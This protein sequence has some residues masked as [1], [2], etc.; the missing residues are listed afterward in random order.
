MSFIR[1][2]KF[3]LGSKSG[4]WCPLLQKLYGAVPFCGRF[5]MQQLQIGIDVD[6]D[7]VQLLD[8]LEEAL[9]GCGVKLVNWTKPEGPWKRW[10]SMVPPGVVAY[11]SLIK[12]YCFQKDF[13]KVYNLLNE[14]Q[15]KGCPPD[16]ATYTIFMNAL[17]REKKI[18][19]RVHDALNVLKDMPRKGV[20]P[21]VKA[22]NTLF[23]AFC[24]Q[25]EEET[26]LKLLMKMEGYHCK[27]DVETYVPLLQKCCK[28]RMKLLF[29][30]LDYMLRNDVSPECTPYSL[31]VHGLC[32]SGKL[33]EACFFFED[34]VSRGMV[35]MDCSGMLMEEFRWNGM[36]MRWKELRS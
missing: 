18:D 26:A 6:V 25:N 22:C 20:I 13:E 29:F 2:E 16:V 15:E 24:A 23:T 30:L 21:N 32:I 8:L 12:E 14:M 27:P 1:V 28:N 34:M 7:E 3:S 31:L 19:G 5:G 35:P 11:T 17:G 9:Y 4:V 33:V 10:K 36:E